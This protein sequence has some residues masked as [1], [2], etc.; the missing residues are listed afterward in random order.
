M[1]TTLIPCIGVFWVI[2]VDT[3]TLPTADGTCWYHWYCCVWGVTMGTGVGWDGGTW[4]CITAPG[5]TVPTGNWT[6]GCCPGT[7]PVE[8]YCGW[9]KTNS[10]WWMRSSSHTKYTEESSTQKKG[11]KTALKYKTQIMVKQCNQRRTDVTKVGLHTR[12]SSCIL[13][14]V[15]D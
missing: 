8:V 2:G 9:K 11:N 6:T 1:K 12:S 10:S 4:L 3:A 7:W 13:H 15:M 5:W 14:E